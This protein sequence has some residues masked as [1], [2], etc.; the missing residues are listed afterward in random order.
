MEGDT[1]DYSTAMEEIDQRVISLKRYRRML[2]LQREKLQGYLA[3]I[4]SR[5]AALSVANYERLEEYTVLEQEA[6]KGLLTVQRCLEPLKVL[7]LQLNPGENKEVQSME[8]RLERLRQEVLQRNQESR[9]LLR[10]QA[11]LLRTEIS[12]VRSQKRPPSIFAGRHEPSFIDLN[13]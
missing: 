11:Q 8:S 9:A 7:Y 5:E 6:I 1:F 13:A 2:D 4:D 10:T 3:V 12:R